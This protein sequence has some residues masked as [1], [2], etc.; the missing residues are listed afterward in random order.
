M[1]YNINLTNI[2]SGGRLI[3]YKI[4]SGRLKSL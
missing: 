2:L 1:L 4:S 3:G